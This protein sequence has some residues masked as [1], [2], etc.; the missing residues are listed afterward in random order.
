M[1]LSSDLNRAIE[2]RKQ[3]NLNESNR[4]LLELVK[5]YHHDTYIFYQC[6]WSFD[7][8]GEETKAIPYYER[9]IELGLAGKDLEGAYLGLGNTYRTIGEY[10]KSK[11]ILLKG[12]TLFPY[13][14]AL[15]VFYSM[16]LYNLK[17]HSK[18][19]EI[20]LTCLV[21]TTANEDIIRYKSALNFY[22]NQLDA[23]WK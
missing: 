1:K 2:L 13:N 17:E 23:V 22:A 7:V 12:I 8:L 6:A 5:T 3:G 4:I 18:A 16:T 11:I 14:K 20:L 9:A 15:P 10:E 21:E 19:M